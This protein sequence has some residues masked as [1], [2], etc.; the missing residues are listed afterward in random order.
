MP[1]PSVVRYAQ[2]AVDILLPVPDA[3][4]LF[5]IGMGFGLWLAGSLQAKRQEQEEA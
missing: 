5:G 2:D 1:F 4:L 3:E